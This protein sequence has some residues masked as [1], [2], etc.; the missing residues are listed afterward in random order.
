MDGRDGSILNPNGYRSPFFVKAYCKGL[1]N[2]DMG[3]IS[4]MN[5]TKGAECCWNDDGLPTQIDVS[6]DIKDLYSSLAMSGFKEN[7]MMDIVANTSYMDFLANMAG[8]NIADVDISRKV[9]LYYY[10]GRS[11]ITQTPDRIFTKFDQSISRLIGN[12]YNRI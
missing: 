11:K 10:L 8:I 12:L 2:I 1:F 4:G 5:V 3:I 9:K 6:I 7:R